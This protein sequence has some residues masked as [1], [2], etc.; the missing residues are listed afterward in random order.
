MPRQAGSAS[1][2]SQTVRG[3]SGHL[4]RQSPYQEQSV[5]GVSFGERN[6]A[7]RVSRPSAR[8]SRSYASSEPLRS[9]SVSQVRDAARY[10]KKRSFSKI[11]IIVVSVLALIV[12]ALIAFVVLYFSN[13]FA[14]EKVSVSGAS[15]LTA[16]ELTELA[17][18]PEDSTLLRIDASGIEQR[19]ESNPWVDNATVERVFPHTIN[20]NI[21][22]RKISAVVDVQIDT[23]KTT[24]TWALSSDGMWLMRIPDRNSE[25]GKQVASQVYTDADSALVISDVP[26]GSVPEAGTF[27]SNENITNALGI[28]D[29]MT[30]ELADQ[31]HRVSASS[32]ESTTLIL[33]N[34]VEIAFGDSSNI[35]DK[36]RVCLQLMQEHPGQIAY[37]NVRTPNKPVWRSL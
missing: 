21:T 11:R 24:E 35:R 36:E 23:D 34:G 29:G 19:L 15:H 3:G 17:A 28:I 8:S 14:V 32:N 6:A 18:V 13:T 22:E 9:V 10:K 25:E 31:V 1:R 2:A 33:D 20:L 30:T 7:S 27:C 5:R 16:E 37:I 26:Y 4:P 12:A